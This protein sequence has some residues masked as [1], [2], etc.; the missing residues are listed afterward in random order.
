ME[1]KSYINLVHGLFNTRV[2][3]K[4]GKYLI[5]TATNVEIN[6]YTSKKIN[7]IIENLVERTNNEPLQVELMFA[8]EKG[9]LS[10]GRRRNLRI[11]LE[12]PLVDLD[13]KSLGDWVALL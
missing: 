3:K 5:I 12:N 13:F 7:E 11:L 2:F 1:N 6:T 10:R 4:D 8:Y 9:S